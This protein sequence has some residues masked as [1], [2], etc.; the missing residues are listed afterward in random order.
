MK[1]PGKAV[2]KL[3]IRQ[4][5]LVHEIMKPGM[6]GQQAVINAGYQPKDEKSA[7]SIAEVTLH[8]PR[9]QQAIAEILAEKY[10]DVGNDAAGVLRD[11]LHDVAATHSEKMKAIELLAKFFGWNAPTKHQRLNANIRYKLPGED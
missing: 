4:R 3:T 7:R 9:V 1:K 5:K 11:I 6:S 10:P 8:R 2:E